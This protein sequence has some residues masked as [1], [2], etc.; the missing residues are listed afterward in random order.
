MWGTI[1]GGILGF[2]AAVLPKLFEIIEAYFTHRATHESQA[3]EIEAASKGVAIARSGNVKIAVPVEGE[4]AAPGIP[5][6]EDEISDVVAESG[7]PAIVS[8]S[9]FL[10]GLWDT[11]RYT[12]RP[13]VTY[14][15][16]ILFLVVKIKGFYHGI[17]VDHTPVIQLLPVIW[18][19]GT[20]SLF[21]A[22]LA[23]WF[24][25]RAFEKSKALLGKQEQVVP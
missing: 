23:F 22:V 13:V 8:R 15:F 14:G 10:L 1:V 12:V 20:E 11:L 4:V 2:M 5:A 16:F 18:D 19:E 7:E 17:L 6:D 3:Q 25:S 9:G 21:A 24:G